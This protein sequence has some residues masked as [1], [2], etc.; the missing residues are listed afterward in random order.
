MT[1]LEP[2]SASEFLSGSVRMTWFSSTLS[3]KSITRVYLSP[4]S[5]I[6]LVAVF[7]SREYTLGMFTIWGPLLTTAFTCVEPTIIWEPSLGVWEIIVPAG[8]SEE[9]FSLS[10]TSS[11]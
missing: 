7:A 6:M 5:S 9:Y 4:A 2:S 8:Y 10:F 1:T 3:L 11:K